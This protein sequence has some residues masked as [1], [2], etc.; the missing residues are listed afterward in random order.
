MF[1]QVVLGQSCQVQRFGTVPGVVN[2][3]GRQVHRKTDVDA[4][5]FGEARGK[6]SVPTV[7]K[8]KC[9]AN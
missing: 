8:T 7:F 3:D 6:R 2:V 9:R 4:N 1:V 5:V